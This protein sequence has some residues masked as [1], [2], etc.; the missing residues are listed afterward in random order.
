MDGY[1]VI[2]RAVVTPQLAEQQLAAVSAAAG[3]TI[4]YD[5][6][7]SVLRYTPSSAGDADATVGAVLT[8]AEA[9]LTRAVRRAGAAVVIQE[10]R[11]LTWDDF[12]AETFRSG[13]LAGVA[14]AV[15]ILGVSRARLYQLVGD[16]KDFPRPI[17]QLKGGP[18]WDRGQVEAWERGWE[19]KRTGRPRKNG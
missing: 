15:E 7:T 19:R 10:A 11:V 2:I 17:A 8:G 9:T 5:S 6:G 18:V 14:E 1:A 16:H 12:E 4:A 3:G 13:V